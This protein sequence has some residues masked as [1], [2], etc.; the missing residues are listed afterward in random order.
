[1]Q[2][3]ASK[4]LLRKGNLTASQQKVS[5]DLSAETWESWAGPDNRGGW[6]SGDL[7]E[8]GGAVTAD[9]DDIWIDTEIFPIATADICNQREVKGRGGERGDGKKHQRQRSQGAMTL[10]TLWHG[11]N[12]PQGDEETR[13]DRRRGG[14]RHLSL[15]SGVVPVDGNLIVDFIDMFLFDLCAVQSLG[16]R[17]GQHLVEIMTLLCGGESLLHHTELRRDESLLRWARER[18]SETPHGR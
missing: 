17:E 13:G 15:P 16:L 12:R 11:A 14:G 2:I 3:E 1:M 8:D 5:L 18:E 7:Q 10:R 6:W 4:A 9:R